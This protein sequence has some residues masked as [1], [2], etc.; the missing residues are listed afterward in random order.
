ML[1]IC[2]GKSYKKI[3]LILTVL[4]RLTTLLIVL[5]TLLIPSNVQLLVFVPKMLVVFTL[6]A[7]L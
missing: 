4:S 3:I 6:M 5:I 7:V 2:K 1:A